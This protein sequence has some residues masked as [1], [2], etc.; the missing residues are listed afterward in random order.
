MENN[1]QHLS[2]DNAEHPIQVGLR[3]DVDTLD[4]TR[5]G[6]PAL[7]NLFAEK[8]IYASFFFSVGP[9]NMGRH[10]WRLIKPAFLIKMLRS[11][12]ASLYGWSILLRGT[13]WP[14]P[15]IA[16]FAG[17]RIQEAIVS[18]HEVGLHAWD[19]QQWQAKAESMSS[20]EIARNMNLGMDALQKIIKKTPC[21]SAAAG[22]KATGDV[23]QHKE[24]HHFLYNSDCRGSHI[25]LPVINGKT[26]KTPQIP[27][28]LPTYDEVIGR[29]GIDDSNYNEYLLS[30]IKP[31]Q[32]NVLTI[33]A[34]VEGM[35]RQTLFRQFLELAE[36]HKISF[37]PLGQ[38]L[39]ENP[40]DIPL[41]KIKLDSIQ[42]REGS[43]CWQAD[44]VLQRKYPE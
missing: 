24:I 17:D 40:D 33:H 30:L 26:L 36:Q 39:P 19:H 44:D 27:V 16:K 18:G 4:G 29:N 5:Q 10:L 22:W 21:C 43:L 25:F 20:T 13:F 38:L 1:S 14:G 28:T 23:L 2:H 8:D 12:A 42:G 41:S 3:V 9:D 15:D 35:S 31:G 34:E 7:L 37:T 6:V 11:N 32:L